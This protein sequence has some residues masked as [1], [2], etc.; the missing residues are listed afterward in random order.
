[1]RLA[2]EKNWHTLPLIVINRIR[3]FP[4]NRK[5]VVW[6]T[7]Y[8]GLFISQIQNV[9]DISMYLISNSMVQILSIQCLF[10]IVLHS[11]CAYSY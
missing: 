4:A 10:L 11:F 2:N 5:F 7:R 3:I 1:M 9:V 8:A 6:L